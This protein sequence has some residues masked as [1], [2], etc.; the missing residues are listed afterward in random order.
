MCYK[1]KERKAV[2]PHKRDAAAKEF[3]AISAS[4]II[5]MFNRLV[6]DDYDDSRQSFCF[7]NQLIPDSFQF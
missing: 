5:E 2:N 6:K 1:M 4:K 3:E 7:W